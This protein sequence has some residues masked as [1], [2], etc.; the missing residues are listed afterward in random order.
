MNDAGIKNGITPAPGFYQ[1]NGFTDKICFRLNVSAV[2]SLVFA[3]HG[4]IASQRETEKGIT[5]SF[6]DP[7]DCYSAQAGVST[8]FA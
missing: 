4:A 5:K 6:D 7:R 3:G 8:P 2:R 1:R